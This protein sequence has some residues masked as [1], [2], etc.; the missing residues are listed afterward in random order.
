MTGDKDTRFA[1]DDEA[2]DMLDARSGSIPP[3]GFAR[4]DFAIFVDETI[5]S[6]ASYAF[7]PG[8]PDETIVLS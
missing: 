6:T 1:T 8:T 5:L 3:L 7:T 2:T 4:A